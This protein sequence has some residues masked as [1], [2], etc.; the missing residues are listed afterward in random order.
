M[1]KRRKPTQL[2]L[3]G[4]SDYGGV[5]ATISDLLDQARRSAARAVNSVLTAAYWEIGR[6]L[7]E[8]EQG[9]QAKAEYGQNLLKQLG[10]DLTARFGRGFSWRNFFS[11]RS[12][13]LGWEILQTSSA[14]F[15]ARVRRPAELAETGGTSL[16]DAFWPIADS[17]AAVCRTRLGRSFSTLLVPLCTAHVGRE[18]T[19]ADLL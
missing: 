5:V 11:M 18:A 10:H 1:A 16:P 7:V 13:Y 2:R 8:F 12:F 19:R 17:A 14:K 15:E 4:T 6:Q 3:P 9:G